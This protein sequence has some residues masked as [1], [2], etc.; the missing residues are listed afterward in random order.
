MQK[1]K[2]VSIRKVLG[3]PASAILYIFSTDFIRAL[4]ISYALAVP[5]I[6]WGSN[7]WLE[8]FSTR[9]P[10]QWQIFVVPLVLLMTITMVTVLAVSMRAMFEA[11]VRSL[12][13]E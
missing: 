5:V 10:L 3:A 4:L 7:N 12:R 6:Y 13:Q 8:N 9:I 2:E 1:T 11:P